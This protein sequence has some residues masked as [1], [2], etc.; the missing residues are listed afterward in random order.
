MQAFILALVAII[1]GL[2]APAGAQKL[3]P[4]T[5]IMLTAP[6]DGAGNAC[7]NGAPCA[8]FSL[9]TGALTIGGVFV[10]PSAAST[11]GIAPVVTSAAAG[12]LV[13]KASAGNLY[14]LTVTTSSAA[15][16]VMVFNA[17]SAPVDGAVTPVHCV[18]IGSAPATVGISWRPLG[19]Y[20]STGISVAFSTTGCF[21]KTASATAFIAG[22]VQ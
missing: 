5:G 13:L 1:L 22:D 19:S 20:Y 8:N 15:G 16:Y 9:S 11:S 14:G 10:V 21:T 7:T 4:T 12:T 2:S 18:Y 3:Q 17:T 6:T